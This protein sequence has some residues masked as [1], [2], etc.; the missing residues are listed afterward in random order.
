MK[1]LSK[2]LNESLIVEG[3][4]IADDVMRS[5]PTDPELAVDQLETYADELDSVKPQQL[6]RIFNADKKQLE[7]YVL[8]IQQMAAQINGITGI[9]RDDYLGRDE[10]PDEIG[11]YL[12]MCFNLQ[13]RGENALDNLSDEM[14][15]FNTVGDYDDLSYL[16]NDVMNNWNQICKVVLGK[17]W[18]KD[19]NN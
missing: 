15:S 19:M 7:D 10:D 5:I 14:D 16:Y 11:N 3:R 6:K 18:S 13:D 9:V 2:K 8:I 12:V 17:E 4:Y 1:S